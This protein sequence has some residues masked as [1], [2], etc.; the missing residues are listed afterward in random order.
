VRDILAL[1]RS[2]IEAKKMKFGLDEADEARVVSLAKECGFVT[3]LRVGGQ[4][5][6]GTISYCVGSEYLAHMIGHDS[7]YDAYWVGALCCYTT[8]CE[9]ISRGAKKFHMGGGRNEY[10]TRLLGVRRDMDRIDIYRSFGHLFL[11]LD[12]VLKAGVRVVKRKAKVWLLEREKGRVTQSVFRVLHALRR[13]RR[14]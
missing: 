9:S 4:I 3:V 5:C 14:N 7:R 8:I 13:L 1:S 11:H 12:E 10:K 2:R 6:A